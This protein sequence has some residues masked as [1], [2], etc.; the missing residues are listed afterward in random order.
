MHVYM[1]IYFT[2]RTNPVIPPQH[3]QCTHYVCADPPHAREWASACIHACICVC[4]WVR[5]DDWVRSGGRGHF[6]EWQNDAR[7][8][9]THKPHPYLWGLIGQ[10]RTMIEWWSTW[11]LTTKKRKEKKPLTNTNAA[12]IP[13]YS[14][15]SQLSRCPFSC[16]WQLELFSAYMK[17]L[18]TWRITGVTFVEAALFSACFLK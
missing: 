17:C 13:P 2:V 16:N 7:R 18:V 12:F 14:D 11:V 5:P 3:I 4:I 6:S 10:L 1:C 15:L 8:G 9:Y